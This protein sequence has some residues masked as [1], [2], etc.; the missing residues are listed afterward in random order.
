MQKPHQ[1]LT[2]LYKFFFWSIRFSFTISRKQ[3]QSLCYSTTQSHNFNGITLPF[4]CC[5]LNSFWII[6][7]SFK[8]NCNL[9]WYWNQWQYCSTKRKSSLNGW[10]KALTPMEWR[11]PLTNSMYMNSPSNFPWF[12]ESSP[13]RVKNSPWFSRKFPCYGFKIPPGLLTLSV[14]LESHVGRQM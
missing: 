9:V 3:G 14:S 6:F 12:S 8:F 2:H 7:H 1:H 4:W 10:V 13:A 11:R 5:F